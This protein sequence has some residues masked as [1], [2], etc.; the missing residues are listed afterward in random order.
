MP[1]TKTKTFDNQQQTTD[2]I[3]QQWFDSTVNI[4]TT[5]PKSSI[6]NARYKV[7]I[8]GELRGYGADFDGAKYSA[9]ILLDALMANA[10]DFYVKIAGFFGLII[11]DKTAKQL[12]IISDHIGSIPLYYWHNN[13]GIMISDSLSFFDKTQL[14]LDPQAIF[15][16][17]YFHCIPAP[18]TIYRG[19]FKVECGHQVTFNRQGFIDSKIL[20]R[21]QYNYSDAP[22]D[23]LYFKCQQLVDNCVKHH[24]TEG[25]GAFLSGG[26]DSSTVAGMMAKNQAQAKTFSIGFEESHYDETR[27][28][29]ITAQHFGTQHQVLKLQSPALIENFKKIAGY[30]DEPFG[31]S[32]AM[33]AFA[34]A[35]FAKESGVDTLLAGDGGDEIF[36][37]NQRYAKQKVFEHFSKAPLAIQEMLE[38]LFCS[39]RLSRLPLGAKAAS[40]I[41]QAKT[42]MPDRLEG[43][44]FLN[45]FPL[46][47]IFCAD[48]LV[49]IDPLQPLQ[50]K[51][52]RYHQTDSC[53]PIEKMLFLDWKFTLADNDL[54]KVKKMC[55]MAGVRVNFPLLEKEL[56]DFTTTITPDK[57]LPGQQ[58]RHFYKQSFAGFLAPETLTK[59]K[60]GFG[61]PFGVWMKQ[62]EELMALASNALEQLA[63]RNIVQAKF[64]EKAQQMH[65][66]EHA[67]YYGEL[68]WILVVLE[69]WFQAH[70]L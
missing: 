61:L 9:Q 29:L 67:S 22:N 69:L 25:C 24:V 58:L 45:R 26:L 54:I 21:P 5:H 48:F 19:V 33:A 68:I 20:Y 1:A 36:A 70:D 44:N 40:Y 4:T 27:Y 50:Q 8:F 17:C 53:N 43:Y 32:S 55:E 14:K 23:Q 46:A 16:Y 47:D 41:N 56:V 28:A 66:G 35:K 2:A 13:D 11:F 60:H 12:H 10:S 42:P 65:Q 64:I 62:S 31:N 18:T 7:I 15:N 37:G 38:A 59:S 3:D 52:A 63:K 39:T 49:K 57:K 34:C 51:Q 30:F 6:E